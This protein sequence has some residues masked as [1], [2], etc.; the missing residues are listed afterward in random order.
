MTVLVIHNQ[1]I[2]RPEITQAL[3]NNGTPFIEANDY[4]RGYDLLTDRSDDVHALILNVDQVMD[5]SAFLHR[6]AM[7]EGHRDVPLILCLTEDDTFNPPQFRHTAPHFW[8]PNPSTDQCLQNLVL[9]AE[10]IFNHR[11]SFRKEI[12]ARQS[13]IGSI[14]S[15]VF[16]IKTFEKTETLTKMISVTCPESDR[17]ALGLFELLGNGNKVLAIV[18]FK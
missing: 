3:E 15:G 6:L 17:V 2:Y 1:H 9:N 4:E 12:K 10:N 7:D 16:R 8:L 14:S 11:R 18:K 5:D 13:V